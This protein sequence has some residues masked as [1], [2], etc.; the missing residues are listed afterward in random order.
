MKVIQWKPPSNL[1]FLTLGKCRIDPSDSIN[2]VLKKLSH[3]LQ[4]PWTSLYVYYYRTLNPGNTDDIVAS[5]VSQAMANDKNIH[6]TTL[7]TKFQAFFGKPIKASHED[8]NML[9][10]AEAFQL[11]K[12][13]I[14]KGWK[15]VTP[16]AF[17]YTSD[18][19]SY[20]PSSI[21]STLMK[22]IQVESLQ[23]HLSLT[24]RSLNLDQE[25]IY[26]TTWDAPRA[27]LF[28]YYQP[29][30]SQQKAILAQT[31]KLIK[32]LIDIENVI[33]ETTDVSE[34]ETQSYMN[35]LHLH[36]QGGSAVNITS[37]FS[38]LHVT[39]E[40][41]FIKLKT[42]IN[43]F[44]KIHDTFL[45]PVW[46]NKEL[47]KKLT[48]VG[49]SSAS[50]HLEYL[51]MRF[52]F[53]PLSSATLVLK[54]D[55]SYDIRMNFSIK[56]KATKKDVQS[57]LDVVNKYILMINHSTR[58]SISPI[59]STV[60][61]ARYKDITI[62]KM[63]M[64]GVASS[65]L[66]EFKF[67]NFSALV[68]SKFYPYFDIIQTEDKN[69]LI[70]QYK[71]IDHYAQYDNMTAFI[72]KHYTLE[73]SDLIHKVAQNFSITEEE[74]SNEVQ[75]WNTSNQV[76][77]VTQ[78]KKKYIKPKHDNYVNI[79]IR[80]NSIQEMRFM[81]SG[82]KDT[83]TFD[84]IADLLCRLSK[85]SLTKHKE[86]S[87]DFLKIFTEEVLQPNLTDQKGMT[88]ADL[89][90]DEISE[91]E[92]LQFSDD[93]DDDDDLKE[94]EKEFA[95]EENA[96]TKSMQPADSESTGAEKR[97]K[98]KGELLSKLRE[99]DRTLFDYKADKTVERTDY[100][101]MCGVVAQ[102]QPV[103]VSKEE[104]DKIQKE[105]PGA[106]HGFVKT[107][108]TQDLA[109][110]N[111]YICP[112][113][114]CPKSRVAI[115]YD[116]YKKAGFKCPNPSIEEEPYLFVK[117]DDKTQPGLDKK[118]SR[119]HF[120]S[121]LDMYTHPDQLCLPCC[122]MTAPKQGSRNQKRQDTCISNYQEQEQV[123][124]KNDMSV[125]GNE[126]YIKG[127]SYS[128]LENF[129]YGLLIKEI[130][131]LFGNPLC[132]D[133]HDGTGIIKERTACYLRR[134]IEHKNQSFM[135]CLAFFLNFSKGAD[136]IKRRILKNLTMEKYM[137]LE[138]G[139]LL[140]LFI[141]PNRSIYD[142][143]HFRA[144]KTFLK[145]ETSYVSRFH[146]IKLL[147]ELQH[148]D[149][150]EEEKL[151]SAKEILREFTIWGSYQ[152]FLEFIAEDAHP[153][154][155]R[156]LMDLFN[157]GE[158][159]LNPGKVL[160]ML[161]EIDT[162]GKAYIQCPL[163]GVKQLDKVGIIIKRGN[164]YEPL[165]RLENIPKKGLQEE[166]LFDLSADLSKD[167]RTLLDF[168]VKNCKIKID[169]NSAKNCKAFLESQ[170]YI[171]RSVVLDYDF[172]VCGLMLKNNL[173]V[174]LFQRGDVFDYSKDHFIY[175]NDVPLFKCTLTS[176]DIGNIYKSLERYTKD[177]RYRIKLWVKD[178]GKLVGFALDY[179]DLFVPV[180]LR[181]GTKTFE[182]FADDLNI[183]IGSA[184][185]PTESVVKNVNSILNNQPALKQEIQ[186]L[187][188]RGNPL[189]SEYK[190]KKLE[191]IFQ[192]LSVKLD[193]VTLDALKKSLRDY[194]QS[195]N[196]DFKTVDGENLF[197]YKELRA[198][199][200]Q[201]LLELKQ[202]PFKFVSDALDDMEIS[203]Y[204]MDTSG[205]MLHSLSSIAIKLDDM[206]LEDVPTKIRKF[207]KGFQVAK[208]KVYDRYWLLELLC[209]LS[210]KIDTVIL[211][212]NLQ[213]KIME[214][215]THDKGALQEFVENPSYETLWKKD[216][217]FKLLD[218]FIES[219]KMLTYY[220]SFY[221]IRLCASVL[222][223]KI[224]VFGHKTLKNPDGIEIIQPASEVSN[225]EP[226]ILLRHYYN[227]FDKRDEFGVFM[228]NS[229]KLVFKESE[230][231]E[232]LLNIIKLKERGEFEIELPLS[233]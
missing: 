141:D 84:N 159:Y 83:Q 91:T 194:M 29:S 77:L 116:T 70:L 136:S 10:E 217:R 20:D 26:V 87:N 139:R 183:F 163:R 198:G 7:D 79:I 82:L 58:A 118:L 16:L 95:D 57:F 15:I 165:V 120:P 78:G 142:P 49:S 13:Q 226:Y 71:K 9:D 6:F 92:T 229:K 230:L 105:H 137:S 129:R 121:F 140:K 42:R 224:I 62:Q 48:Q 174:P 219:Q 172:K 100:A 199:K 67:K 209:K 168:F 170:G 108:S 103:V 34:Y 30:E 181:H 59:P 186:F 175:I 206:D 81:V 232:E 191:Y 154:D 74:A 189:P 150:Y 90:A 215:Y 64:Y 205:D 47:Y 179:N 68:K 44:F 210:G 138:N 102:R 39:P 98:T 144:F 202:N 153:K 111:F 3:V 114:W 40:M 233:K 157:M 76:E 223:H 160:L 145:K 182:T 31:N 54:P 8:Y 61:E 162:N 89:D 17:Q 23:N 122:F 75:K 187:F 132:G 36:A 101:S 119:P 12:S 86:K 97:K 166:K 11:V 156:V 127:E 134:G 93:F 4:I 161:I 130:H 19:V 21:S 225:K 65:Q 63:V 60:F 85:M 41:P 38:A 18:V 73:K 221:E 133:R 188:D 207:M 155:H 203:V 1:T 117:E 167:F 88:F 151:H 22:D 196:G 56:V 148:V 115:T 123:Q 164:Y 94:L 212:A 124:D 195:S 112:N 180:N 213:K 171:T 173:Y 185:T 143:L 204:D 53:A 228:Y 66:S 214:E 176:K 106:I 46:E 72:T 149:N 131:G 2:L 5:F 113:I 96:D 152:R 178:D 158:T 104:I 107:G 227:R 32:E 218:S 110:K 211:S 169:P 190:K 128:P 201:T 177:S 80:L 146:L 208:P 55:G 220:P 24:L 99:A 14:K 52:E 69:S 43:A 147:E 25:E 37:V 193:D 125:M 51:I 27:Y 109:Q 45:A 216:K 192:T 28:P 222:E 200:I 35:F 33:H 184:L 197:N 231:P 135:A 126:K 50:A